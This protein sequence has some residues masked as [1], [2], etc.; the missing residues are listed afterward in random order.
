[1]SAAAISRTGSTRMDDSLRSI[2]QRKSGAVYS[3]G[4]DDSVYEAVAR[5]SDKQV[6]ALLVL[7]NGKLAGIVSERDYARKVILKGK[8]S[9]ETRVGEIMSSPVITVTPGTPV[10]QCMRLM[11]S[12]RIRHLAVLEGEQI[13]GVVSIGDLVTW[14]IESQE[15]TIRHLE[16]YINGSYPG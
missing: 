11:S 6:G 2:L 8:S 16:S 12:H 9:R 7:A 14:L 1:M 15:Q 3:V 13:A 10:S 4:Q 5:M